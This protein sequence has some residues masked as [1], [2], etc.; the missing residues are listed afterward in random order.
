MLKILN[1]GIL[2]LAWGIPFLFMCYVAMT[3]YFD[4]RQRIRNLAKNITRYKSN[5]DKISGY[6]STGDLESAEKLVMSTNDPLIKASVSVL[7]EGLKSRFD[8]YGALKDDIN[9]NVDNLLKVPHTSVF[10]NFAATIL[11][12]GFAGTLWSFF[13]TLINFDASKGFQ[14]L[15]FYL[16]VGIKSSFFAA[17]ASGLMG[18]YYARLKIKVE[19]EIEKFKEEVFY[20]NLIYF[21]TH[22]PSRNPKTTI[23]CKKDKSN[24]TAHQRE[25]TEVGL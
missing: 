20:K 24:K 16:A 15:F 10:E 18:S 5:R 13:Y 2:D 25:L 8:D 11:V 12:I 17:C 7:K 21:V 4:S 1:M 14:Q 9:K 6:L 22:P 3:K 23:C 19:H